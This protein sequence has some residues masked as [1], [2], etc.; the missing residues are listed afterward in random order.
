[1]DKYKFDNPELKKRTEIKAELYANNNIR[2]YN[3]IDL[4]SNVSVLKDDAQNIDI[5]KIREMLDKKY[6]D[7]LP[8]RKSINIEAPI[9]EPKEDSSLFDTKEY[10]INE[11]LAKA[12]T[13]QNIDYLEERL[14]KI[15][16]TNNNILE[17]LDIGLKS[18]SK[19]NHFDNSN[20]L[21]DLINTIT[22]LEQE[23]KDKYKQTDSDLLDL[24]PTEKISTE[25]IANSFFTGNLLVTDKDYEDFKDI[26]KDI[27]SNSI[28]IKILVIVFILLILS[29]IIYFLN[30]YF[31]WGLF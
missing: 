31:S 6:R 17:N 30:S 3:D 24:S 25:P 5:D 20:E 10:N 29:L 18:K 7:N 23:S 19:T 13:E 16:N 21:M 12:K 28:L 8:R 15:N 1:M 9:D 4:N 26:Q 11:I 27:K 14:K 22:L 2:T